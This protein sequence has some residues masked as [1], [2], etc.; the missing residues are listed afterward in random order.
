MMTNRVFGARP[1]FNELIKR[2]AA[3][4]EDTLRP[5]YRAALLEVEKTS[6]CQSIAG[7]LLREKVTLAMTSN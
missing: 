1:Y 4:N 2:G 7:S 3:I 5:Q 6:K